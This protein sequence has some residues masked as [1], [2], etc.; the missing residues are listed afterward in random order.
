ML[1]FVALRHP[2]TT[3]VTALNKPD[4]LT[5]KIMLTTQNKHNLCCQRVVRYVHECAPLP[6]NRHE[7]CNTKI[8]PCHSL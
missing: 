1:S 2:V 7:Q 6:T 8:T 4:K 5:S 3:L